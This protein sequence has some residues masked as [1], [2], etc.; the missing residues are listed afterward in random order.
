MP[1]GI[2]VPS[3]KVV[4]SHHTHGF[5]EVLDTFAT[6][7]CVNIATFNIS[8]EGSKLLEQLLRVPDGCPIRIVSNIPG[9]WPI[10]HSEAS[11][12]R[13]RQRIDDYIKQIDRITL[14]RPVSVYFNFNSHCKVVATDTLMY[15]GSANFSDESSKNFECGVLIS[16]ADS[17]APIVNSIFD[18]LVEQAIEFTNSVEFRLML[19]CS[20]ICDT[21][22]WFRR[23]LNEYLHPQASGYW[24]HDT[25]PDPM[26]APFSSAELDEL[27]TVVND[28][29][30]LHWQLE[31]HPAIESA[32][33]ELT[34]GFSDPLSG[35]LRNGGTIRCF[36][37]FN[38]YKEQ[39]R[40]IGR[41]IA[42][43]AGPQDPH[44]FADAV[45]AAGDAREES[46]TN[47]LGDLNQLAAGLQ[48][49]SDHLSRLGQRIIAADVRR[50]KIDNT[51]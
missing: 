13:A 9:R 11:R 2:P 14:Q 29:I 6:A 16:G 46:R 3:A 23:E 20:E 10:Y 15:I 8:T 18:E 32:I 39:M 48:S 42:A 43:Y 51:Q 7:K 40:Y 22:T 34:N 30:R 28:I 35:L 37:E 41:S 33:L 27:Q 5:E 49:M 24:E 4:F 31:Q 17:I 25:I 12:N 47:A 19:Q 21:V 44:M 45:N 1:T 50:A 26:V 38:D 36:S